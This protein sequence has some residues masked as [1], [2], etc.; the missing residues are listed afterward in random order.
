MQSGKCLGNVQ[1]Y[2]EEYLRAEHYSRS[3]SSLIYVQSIYHRSSNV[4]GIIQAFLT[5]HTYGLRQPRSPS[6]AY[7]PPL[8]ENIGKL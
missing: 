5:A 4:V 2:R 7:N 3:A 6:R 1:Q 8:L